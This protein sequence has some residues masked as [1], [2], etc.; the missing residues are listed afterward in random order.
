MR[1]D[2]DAPRRMKMSFARIGCWF[3]VPVI[4]METRCLT[5]EIIALP[6]TLSARGHPAVSAAVLEPAS[7]IA[8]KTGVDRGLA[9]FLGHDHEVHPEFLQHP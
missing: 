6:A 2:Q 3:L 1:I 7:L 5:A 9:G 8:P 4:A